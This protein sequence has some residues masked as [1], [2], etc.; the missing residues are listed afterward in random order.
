[1]A[2]QFT[3]ANFKEAA[4]DNKGVTL[5][6]FGAEWCGPC[7]IIAPIIEQLATEYDGQAV[8][9]K[10]DVD[11]NPEVST[12]YG[13]RSIPTLLFLRDGEIVEKHVGLMTKDG[14]K[15]KLDAMMAVTA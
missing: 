5:I 3:D 11:D 4:L 6:D 2:F 10:L 7:R 14:L 13:V 8:I 12:K 15:A 1:M 9:G